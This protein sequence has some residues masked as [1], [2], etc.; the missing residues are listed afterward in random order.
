MTKLSDR[1]PKPPAM[2][3]PAV[4]SIP[5]K[6]AAV[7]GDVARGEYVVLPGLGRAWIQLLSRT[8]MTSIE[9]AV[10]DVLPKAGIPALQLHAFTYDQERK[11]RM[12]AASARD[13][14]DHTMPFGT[15]QEWLAEDDDIIFASGLVLDDVKHRLDPVGVGTLDADT[16]AE[17]E[18]AFKKKDPRLLMLSG[19]A[20]LVRWLTSGALQLSSSPTRSSSTSESSAE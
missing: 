2:P 11:A 5:T 9:A 12:L 3:T 13:P 19:V 4:Q 6:L 18:S 14:D 10:F 7:R 17:L 16:E 1:N 20:T 8:M 15:L